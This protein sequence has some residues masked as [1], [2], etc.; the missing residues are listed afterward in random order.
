MTCC[1][2]RSCSSLHPA[3][4]YAYK[5]ATYHLVGR[6]VSL[7]LFCLSA[8]QLTE[9]RRSDGQ[10]IPASLAWTWSRFSETEGMQQYTED[11]QHRHVPDVNGLMGLDT[12][13][14]SLVLNLSTLSLSSDLDS[15]WLLLFCACFCFSYAWRIGGEKHSWVSLFL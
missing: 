11:K 9:I 5:S 12:M 8:I 7:K 2:H 6:F 13:L 3:T 1:I 10:L 4:L 15:S 14:F